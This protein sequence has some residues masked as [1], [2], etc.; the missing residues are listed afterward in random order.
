MTP[1]LNLSA[2][3]IQAILYAVAILPTMFFTRFRVDG[4]EY[5]ENLPAGGI[6]VMSNHVGQ[7]DP[8]LL[9]LALPWKMRCRPA[10]SVALT[11][12]H[13][14][15]LPLGKLLF[16]GKFFKLG[17]AYPAYLKQETLAHSLPHHIQLLA[18]NK[19]VAIFPEGGISPNGKLRPARPGVAFLAHKTKSIVIPAYIY[20]D[21]DLT[22][23][24]FFARK[25]RMGVRF[26]KPIYFSDY[27][28]PSQSYNRAEYKEIANRMFEEVNKLSHEKV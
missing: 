25:R 10:Y 14:L 5:F 19:T 21:Y 1:L 16:G 11:K 2:L 9:D 26:G 15:H 12:E 24:D 27:A 28:D 4:K 23:T 7:V 20:G 3:C 17:G 13:Y 8:G 22:A 18:R 6:I